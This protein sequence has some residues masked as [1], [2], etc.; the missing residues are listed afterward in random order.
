MP[1]DTLKEKTF[2]KEAFT[3]SRFFAKSRKLDPAK[4]SETVNLRKFILGKYSKI[5]YSRKLIPAKK[6]HFY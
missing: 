4:N 6:K 3:I 5:G 1:Q 2:A